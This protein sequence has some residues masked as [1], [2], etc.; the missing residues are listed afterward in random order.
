[1]TGQTQTTEQEQGECVLVYDDDKLLMLSLKHL[2][3]VRVNLTGGYAITEDAASAAM[4]DPAR[5]LNI[6]AY[7]KVVEACRATLA[8]AESQ[9]SGPYGTTEAIALAR[10]ALVDVHPT[11]GAKT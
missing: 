7:P 1:M 4:R 8:I 5:V 11:E 2:H 10:A 9:L 6:S 3:I